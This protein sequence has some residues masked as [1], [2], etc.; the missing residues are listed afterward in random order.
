MKNAVFTL[1]PLG[2][3]E[4]GHMPFSLTNVPETFQCL[5]EM[6]LGDLHLIRLIICLY[7]VTS[8][9]T[10]LGRLRAVLDNLK[11][12]GLKLK[13]GNCEFFK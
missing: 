1:G 10:H 8:P 3:S 9:K 12:A 6:C 4:W 13:P 2:C 7:L 5:I 11:A